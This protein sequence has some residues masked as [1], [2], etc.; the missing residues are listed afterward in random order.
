MRKLIVVLGATALASCNLAPEFRQPAAPVSPNY[1]QPSEGSRLASNIGWREFFGDTRLQAYIEAALAN[2]QD[3]AQSVA[4]IEQARAQYRI[5]EADRLPQVDLSGSGTR[6][7]SPINALGF[8]NTLPGGGGGEHAGIKGRGCRA[9][10]SDAGCLE[11]RAIAQ[12]YPA[13]PVA[14]FA[15]DFP[16][17][18]RGALRGEGHGVGDERVHDAVDLPEPAAVARDSAR[19]GIRQRL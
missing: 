17:A 8:G 1:A 6:T 12:A 19:A 4:R 11:R 18:P 5:T 16:R 10:L 3:L 2:N 7:R 14:S 9:S 15:G 13:A